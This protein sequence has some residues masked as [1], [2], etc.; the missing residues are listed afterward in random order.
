M[1]VLKTDIKSVIGDTS[2]DKW[3][4]NPKEYVSQLVVK[5]DKR[6]GLRSNDT[7]VTLAETGCE[8]YQ[9]YLAC[10]RG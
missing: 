1:K 4:K 7:A 6:T 8:T 9:C 3:N 2:R 5:V 10:L